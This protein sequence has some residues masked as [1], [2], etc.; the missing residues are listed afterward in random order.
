MGTPLRLA[1]FLA[2]VL[3]LGT[4]CGSSGGGG[5]LQMPLQRRGEKE[6]FRGKL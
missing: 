2:V 5:F 3:M 1:A 6:E 4:S